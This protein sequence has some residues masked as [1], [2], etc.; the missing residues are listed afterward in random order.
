MDF[1]EL[2]IRNTVAERG[3]LLLRRGGNLV[4]EAEKDINRSRE[5]P[6][7]IQDRYSTEVVQI[8]IQ[9]RESFVLRQAIRVQNKFHTRRSRVPLFS[10]LFVCFFF[11]LSR[12]SELDCLVYLR[13]FFFF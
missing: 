12:G 4:V 6:T 1:L 8:A 3:L 10:T 7:D 5:R 9:T 2:A 11:L 13:K